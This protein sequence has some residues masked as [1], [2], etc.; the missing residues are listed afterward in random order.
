MLT[1][2]LPISISETEANQILGHDKDRALAVARSV[3]RRARGQAEAAR[4]NRLPG[5]PYVVRDPADQITPQFDGPPAIGHDAGFP[6][7]RDTTA[8]KARARLLTHGP[9]GGFNTDD[10]STSPSYSTTDYR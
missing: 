8:V 1:D 5:P 4:R 10:T 7:P 2:H 3:V 9:G 6:D